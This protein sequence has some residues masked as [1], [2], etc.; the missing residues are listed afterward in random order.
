MTVEPTLTPQQ[1]AAA[2]LLATMAN[3]HVRRYRRPLSTFV[4]S[5]T[6]GR[7]SR[8]QTWNV[9]PRLSA[10]WEDK[11]SSDRPGWRTRAA[12]LDSTSDEPVFEVDYQ[13]CRRCRLGWVEQPFTIAPYQ[14]HGLASA[15]LA[16]LQAEHPPLSWHTL[17]G[18]F[19]NSR[20]FW[21]TVGRGVPGG[22]QQRDLC[23][24]AMST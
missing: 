17:G 11:P 23:T 4:S 20:P 14:R 3:G 1:D 22:Y 13:T 21:M 16:A 19:R 7:R 2:R 24:H 8:G 10:P 15:A 5:A 6:G 9:M 12:Y 18:H